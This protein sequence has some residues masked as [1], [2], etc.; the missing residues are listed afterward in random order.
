M[1]TGAR[2]T[3][4]TIAFVAALISPARAQSTS[5]KEHFRR[6]AEHYAAERY[7]EAAAEFQIAFET[8]GAARTL[9]AWAQAERLGG[10]CEAAVALYRRLLSRP[11]SD[12]QAQ[13]A[14]E[15]MSR[16]EDMEPAAEDPAPDTGQNSGSAGEVIAPQPESR[17]GQGTIRDTTQPLPS[18][19]MEPPPGPEGT[20]KAWMGPMAVGAAGVI[21]LGIGVG[22]WV[23]SRYEAGAAEDPINSQAFLDHRARA[24]SHQT[25][26]GV[27]LAVGGAL[28]GAAALWWFLQ[29]DTGE[30]EGESALAAWANSESGGVLVTGSF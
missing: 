24:K 17:H 9:F 6:G 8:G 15:A 25:M 12:E 1:K 2:F 18:T 22:F 23:S 4:L 28:C 20:Q 7:K 27:S 5:A 29:D 11:L 19:A 3:V 13:K 14:R 26:A 16:C 21:G 10:D 30:A